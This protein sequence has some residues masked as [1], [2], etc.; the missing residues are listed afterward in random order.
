MRLIARNSAGELSLTRNYVDDNMPEY[1]ILSHTWGADTEEVT[2]QDLVNGTG[3]GKS[4]YG[5]VL[6]CGEQA[7][8]DGLEYFWVDT[9]CIDKSNS[10]ELAEAIN[11]MFRWYRNAAKCYVY[12]SDVSTTWESAFRESRW[13]RRGWT[14][15]ELLA[16]MSVAFFSR[17]GKR[18]GDKRTLEQQVHEITGI[19]ISALQGSL[20]CEFSVTER[21]SWAE[22]RQTTR[23]EDS[24]YSLLGLDCLPFATEAP[25]NVFDRQDELTCLPNTRVDL[26]QEVYDWADGKDE[27]YIFWLNG[28]AGTGKS[29]VARTVARRHF[30]RESLGASFFFSRGGG[31]VS[32]AG[33]FVTSIAVQLANNVPTVRQ[34]IYDAITKR[35]DV[36][37]QS[38]RDQWCQLVLRPLLR[39][40]SSSPPSSYMLIVDALDE[41]DKEEHIRIILGVLAEVQ[42]LKTVRLRVFLTSRPETP[43]R[44][45]FYQIP[46]AEYHNFVLHSIPQSI[47]NHDISIFLRY[48]LD[49]VA[50]ER[51]LGAGWPG[52]QVVK[53]LVCNASGL[54]IWAATACRFIREGRRFAAKRLGMIMKSGSTINAPEKHLNEIYLTV[55]QHSIS[56][57]Y[58][59]EESDELYCILKTL[60]G[61]IVILFSPLPTQS[62]SRLV[63]VS[64]QELDQTL[65]DLHAILDVPKDQT[66]PVHLHHPSFRDFLLNRERCGDS[67]F[68]VDEKQAHRALANNCIQLMS[69]SLK[70]DV[71]GQKAP[72]TLVA[73][74]ESSQLKQCLPLEVRYACLYW[75]QHLQ[76]SGTQLYDE[77]QVYQFL[78]AHLLHWLEALG[79]IGKASEGI[80]ALL[81][82]E[83]QVPADKNWGFRTFIH[84]AKRFALYNRSVIEQA[85]LQLYCS[86]LVFAPKKSIV[87]RQFEKCIPPWIQVKSEIQANWS[88]ALQTL[89]VHSNRVGSVAFSPDGKVVA[90]GSDDKTVRLCDAITGAVLQTLEDHSDRVK[91]VT[92]SP[93]G[94]TVA[95]GSGDNTIRLWDAI[96]GV[97][98]QILE[99]HSASVSSVAFS[100]DSKVVASGSFDKT[101][102]L[103]DAIS[104]VLLQT[105]KGHVDWVMS[106]AFSPDS[107]VVASSSIDKTV[108]LWVAV[109]GT[110]LQTVEVHSSGVGSVT[111]SPD[112]KVVASG[113]DDKTVRLCD[114]IT[115]AVL[116]TLE[117][118]SDWVRSVAFS[119]DGKTVA[120]GSGDNTVRLWDAA[121]GV[122]LQTLE[123]HSDWV[124]SVAFSPDSTVVVSGSDDY[125]VCLWD[126]VTERAPQTLEG[127]S[128]WVRSVAF[129]PDGTVVASGSG[130]KKVRFWDG[131]TG[132]ALQTLEGHSDWVTSVAFSPDGKIVASGS[133]DKTVRLWG[134]T[135]GAALQTLEGGWV[136]S[137]AFSPDGKMVASGSYDSKVRLW[138]AVTGVA[139]QILEGHS[140]TIMTASFSSDSKV[141]ASGSRDKTVRLWDVITGAVLQTLEG[142]SDLVRSVTFSPD[143]KTVAS[144]SDDNTVRLWDAVIGATLQTLKGHLGWVTSVAFS[145]DVNV[146]ASASSDNTVRLWDGVTGATLQTL[147]IGVSINALSFSISGQYLKT[148]RGRKTASLGTSGNERSTATSR[149]VI[150][151]AT[152]CILQLRQIIA[153]ERIGILQ[154]INHYFADTLAKTREERV[155]NGLKEVGLE[156][157]QHQTIDLA[158][159]TRAAH[160]NNEDQAVNLPLYKY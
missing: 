94:K 28:L 120:S 52:E 54:F 12:L 55:L 158:A 115:G 122:A 23:A 96:T 149:T 95:S 106:V 105:L 93:D 39:L 114:A 136:S 119:P 132:A 128:D 127:H 38:L 82:L 61:S 153:D 13:F 146:V 130:D 47:I 6:F 44:H 117:G 78:Q 133:G 50:N 9:C 97:V 150:T 72:G 155:L 104:G 143:G 135:T 3:K 154:T 91:S 5:K 123:G 141:V 116:Q 83:D 147:E 134:T 64:Q 24:A 90:S 107:N 36:A 124:M 111:F 70:Q 137:V 51:S 60:L 86:A 1:A 37:S 19:A 17:E 4:G 102:R 160:L 20:L 27:R 45:G 65:D 139:L 63:D 31:D 159:I 30:E 80:L 73:N 41:C 58:T 129:S 126:T 56:P 75:T 11:S 138:D 113:S 101:V 21:M 49:C 145:P 18:L 57:D 140:R 46:D 76:K 89:E 108:R 142:H 148:D 43:I 15:Q 110:L 34:Y 16:P 74:I 152:S 32:H 157:G 109:T 26:L 87:R 22:S 79:W 33:K 112:G 151:A 25:F 100:P 85:P 29:T 81:S 10:T 84:D 77:Y 66:C 98:L 7:R 156:D 68:W 14:L 40:G 131:V 53:R 2:F 103:W 99:G 118:H 59:A 71:C 48:K 42:T 125:T 144:G 88:A 62:L 35:N 69:N 67:R 92:F 121:T 8:R